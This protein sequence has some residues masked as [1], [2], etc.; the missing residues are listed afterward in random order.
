MDNLKNK[1]K[2]VNLNI[3]NYDTEASIYFDSINDYQYMKL[4][5]EFN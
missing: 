4:D 3:W 5:S 1:Y 2:P